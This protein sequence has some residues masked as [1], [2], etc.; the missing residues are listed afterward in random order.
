MA[1]FDSLVEDG[2][3]FR[4]QLQKIFLRKIKR[5]KKNAKRT[6]DFDSEEESDS[7]EED[8]DDDDW[9]EDEAEEICP[10]G[11]DQSLYEKVCDLREKR[12]DQEEIDVEL[13]KQLETFN[14][15][16]ESLK[17]KQNLINQ[18]VKAIN[19]EI[20]SF[21]KEKQAKLNEIVLVVT[22][23]MHQIEYLVESKLP[24]DLSEALVFPK[25]SLKRLE[26][27]VGEL[28]EEKAQLKQEQKELRKQHK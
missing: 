16:K 27:R 15:E 10:P 17:K 3:T 4:E 5:H 20:I 6:E 11:C 2:S 14:K 1:E 22:L 23:K 18:S 25:T 19:E 12:L 28:I 7:E 13:K 21:Q 9:D 8:D 26:E 24:L